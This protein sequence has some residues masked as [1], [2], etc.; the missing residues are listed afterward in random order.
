MD[1]KAAKEYHAFF[2]KR[3]LQRPSFSRNLWWIPALGISAYYVSGWGGVAFGSFLGWGIC[4]ILSR[5]DNLK[6]EQTRLELMRHVHEHTDE[7]ESGKQ[8]A[9]IQLEIDKQASQW[10]IWK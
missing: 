10:R 1:S 8:L 9:S 6:M 4:A 7:A 3:L 5:L 2:C